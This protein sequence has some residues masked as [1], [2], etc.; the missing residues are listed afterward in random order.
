ML[1]Y[2]KNYFNPF[3]QH[4][5]RGGR[6]FLLKNFLGI[7]G[8]SPSNINRRGKTVN[9]RYLLVFVFILLIFGCVTT[10]TMREAPLFKGIPHT[11]AAD[12]DQL[13]KATRDAIHLLG[14]YIE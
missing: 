1:T 5:V 14:F 7:L 2:I 4:P 8:K 11:F 3:L 6:D 12:Q 9:E 10:T 13:L